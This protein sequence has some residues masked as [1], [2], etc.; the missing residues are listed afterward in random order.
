MVFIPTYEKGSMFTFSSHFRWIL[1]KNYKELM[2]D[3]KCSISSFINIVMELKKCCNHGFLVRSPDTTETL[4]KSRFEVLNCNYVLN[5][6]YKIKI[7]YD[8]S[9]PCKYHGWGWVRKEERMVGG[10]GVSKVWHLN[11]S[12]IHNILSPWGFSN[13]ISLTTENFTCLW[14][15]HT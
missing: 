12:V 4:N 1:T 3:S 9:R 14:C 5:R 15:V 8:M 13:K 6:V 10:G 7:K 2:K 11:C